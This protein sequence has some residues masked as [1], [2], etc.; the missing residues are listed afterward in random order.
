MTGSATHVVETDAGRFEAEARSVNHRFMKSTVR[1]HG[2]VPS[3]NDVVEAALRK[4]VRRGHVTVH[5]RFRPGPATDFENRIHDEAF[6]AA[7]RRLR[8]LAETHGLDAVSVRDV[9][10]IPGVLADARTLGDDESLQKSVRE[11]VDGLV[12]ALQT[13]REH[14]GALMAKEVGSIVDT[15]AEL[16][17]RIAKRADEVPAAYRQ[18]LEERLG[19]LLE[20]SGVEPDPAQVARECA[21]MA[22]RSDVREEIARLGAHVEHTRTLLKDGGAVGR[23]LD[24]LAQE[25]HRETNTIASKT[26][27]LEMNRTVLDLR[28]AVERLREQVQNLE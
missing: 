24:F 21:L 17:E 10:A 12:S 5:V 16:T 2:P 1:T 22:E 20:G 26:S 9:L 23:R 11:V 18:R 6:A 7:A 13:A 14:E 4:S 15:I 8:E 19:R 25:F 27:D 28:A 3:V